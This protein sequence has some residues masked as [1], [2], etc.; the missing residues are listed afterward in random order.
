MPIFRNEPSQSLARVSR[1]N[2]AATQGAIDKGRRVVKVLSENYPVMHTMFSAVDKHNYGKISE[3]ID[4]FAKQFPNRKVQVLDWGCG[5]G[6]AAKQLAEEHPQTKVFGFS[7]DSY[8][9]H[10]FSGKATILATSQNAFYRYLESKKIKFDVIYSNLGLVYA[11]NQL[12]EIK[13]LSKFLRVGG[14]LFTGFGP[15]HPS[16]S[17]LNWINAVREAGFEPD[18]FEQKTLLEEVTWA[19]S[20]TRVK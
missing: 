10:L 12:A 7:K 2:R 6:Y 1:L 4:F 13:K 15:I 19:I 11:E 9:Q 20:L 18:F 3:A 5:W 17:N 14:K 16:Q 8:P